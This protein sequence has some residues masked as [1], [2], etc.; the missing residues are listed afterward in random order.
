LNVVRVGW[1][2]SALAQL[3]TGYRPVKVLN[4]IYNTPLPAEA[5]ALLGTL[6]PQR[7]RLSRNES[8]TFKS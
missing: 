4:V 8:W 5:V 1:P 7:W 6:F 3:V 2:S